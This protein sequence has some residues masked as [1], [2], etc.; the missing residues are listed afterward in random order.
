MTWRLED[1]E[2]EPVIQITGEVDVESADEE[3]N[4]RNRLENDFEE[5]IS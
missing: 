5:V 3:D 4:R 2:D 1:I